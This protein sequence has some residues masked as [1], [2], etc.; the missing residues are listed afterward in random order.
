M[1][2]VLFDRPWKRLLW[3]ALIVGVTYL[4]SALRLTY[5]RDDWYYAYDALVGPAGVFRLM[6]ASDRPARGP[7]FELYQAAFGISPLPYHLAMF[8]WRLA[9]GLATAWLFRLLWP[10]P[11]RAAWAAGLLFALYPGFTWWVSGIEYQPMVASA[12][13]MVLSLALTLQALRS[14]A[15]QLRTLC[16]IGAICAGWV[17]LSLVE[18]AAGMEVFRLLLVYL[19]IDPH[20]V[21]TL[22]RRVSLAVRRW[23]VYLIIPA[24]FFAWRFFI[25]TSQRK[26][27]NLGAQLG[28]LLTDPL[29]TGLHWSMNFLL[30][31]INVTFSAWVV[32]LMNSFF[33]GTLREELLG[34]VLALIAAGAAWLLLARNGVEP[35]ESGQA[36][37]ADW[38]IRAVWLGLAGVLLGI[39]SIIAANR[40][41]TFPNF[42]HYAL[43]ASLG[44]AFMVTGLIHAIANRTVRAS[45]LCVLVLLS[46]MT[47]QG[48]GTAAVQE[49][50]L[51]ADFWHQVA[52]RAPS[53]ATGTTLLAYYP[54]LDYADDTDIVWGPANFIYYRQRQGR[55]PVHVALSV[56]PTDT[57]AINNI[58]TGHDPQDAS[59]RAHEMT[60]D[61]G[62]VLVLVQSAQN[63]CVRVLDLRWPTL[64][65][66]DDPALRVLA[67]FS[68][69]TDVAAGG[70]SADPPAFVFGPEPKHGWCFYFE[71]AEA[72]AQQA[73]WQ[74]VAAIQKDVARL[75]LHPN[76]QI[77]WMPF[78]QA[79]AY[80]GNMQAVKE[81]ATRINTEKLYKLE[82]CQNLVNM[83]NNGYAPPPEMQTYSAALFCGGATQ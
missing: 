30:S 22:G 79:Q 31:V 64:S 62:N 6:F 52:W 58:V 11:R 69:A 83:A 29:S 72:A 73:N 18:Y 16:V 48:L 3:F 51:I 39:A 43:P 53:I 33:S 45:V 61:Y 26:A 15:W 36:R 81:L 35:D 44:L 40:E 37:D 12:A 66:G 13:L 23:L 27:T 46:A 17:Y 21:R 41:I 75:G 9:G 10:R 8:F 71:K 80:L 14:K 2:R 7:F 54:N 32:P 38:P 76:D 24:A 82:A 74:E 65:V 20:E 59:Y 68:H 1:M 60:V 25:F 77:E 42:S 70:G 4:P 56:V 28:G 57:S 49:E 5:Y 47:H 67:P 63:S 50:G 78:L 55:L 19:V 34:L